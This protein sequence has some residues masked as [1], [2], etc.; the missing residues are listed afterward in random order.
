MPKMQTEIVSIS[1]HIKRK[2]IIT[3]SKVYLQREYTDNES[4]LSYL[5]SYFAIYHVHTER[6]SKIYRNGGCVH[7]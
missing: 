6:L 4:P 7:L 1:F 3:K 5:Q 2:I